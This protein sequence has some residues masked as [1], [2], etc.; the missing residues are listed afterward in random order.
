MSFQTIFL[1][2]STGDA[3]S[4]DRHGNN[5]SHNHSSHHHHHRHH[6][7]CF[8]D[9]LFKSRHHCRACG[10]LVCNACSTQRALIP[11]GSCVL[12]PASEIT[13][14]ENELDARVPQ[15]VCITCFQELAPLQEE[16]KRTVSRSCVEL[17]S[18]RSNF[19]RF[20]NLPIQ[21]T[22]QDEIRKAANTLHNYMPDNEIEGSDTIPKEL[23]WG[24]TGIA[25]LT[26]VKGGF[27]FSGTCGTG[28]VLAKLPDG[29]WS[30]PSSI[31]LL[32]VGWGFQVGGEVTDL[33][34]VLNSKE[35]ID[36]FSGT[37]HFSLGTELGISVGPLGRTA[38]S[39]IR[40]GKGGVA[41][42][43]AYAHSRGLFVGV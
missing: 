6:P 5:G 29:S 22:L 11:L 36:T 23:L 35:A 12:P 20:L 24:C 27:F 10:K 28:L 31:C 17:E 34:F 19:G 8:T 15:R 3:L 18:D 39:D 14:S 13:R 33:M 16:L 43:F 7:A 4:G 26:V 30:A 32:N 40:A 25:F 2:K 41:S 1:K 37:A 42:A 9:A 21:I 38:G